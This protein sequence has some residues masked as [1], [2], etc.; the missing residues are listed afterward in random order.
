MLAGVTG[1]VYHVLGGAG[2]VLLPPRGTLLALAA[3]RQYAEKRK[4]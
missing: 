1:G 2:P 3:V 4:E